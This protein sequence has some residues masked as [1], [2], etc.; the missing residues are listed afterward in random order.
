MISN[1]YKE[2]CDWLQ[3]IYKEW[4][5]WLQNIYKEWCDWLQNILILSVNIDHINP[6]VTHVIY[7]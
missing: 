6:Y 3:N 4:C 1:I 5:D 2:W 7:I